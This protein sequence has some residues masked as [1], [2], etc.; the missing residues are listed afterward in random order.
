MGEEEGVRAVG[1]AE[2]KLISQRNEELILLDCFEL[3]WNFTFW[4][5]VSELCKSVNKTHKEYF[6][7]ISCPS[8]ACGKPNKMIYGDAMR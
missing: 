3:G 5:L 4:Q 2:E 6:I 8:V 7:A 1:W